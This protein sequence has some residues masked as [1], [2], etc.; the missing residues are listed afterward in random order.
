MSKLFG[1]SARLI[2]QEAVQSVDPAAPPTGF[3]IIYPKT[4]GKWYI[5][6]SDGTI[7]EITNQNTAAIN[8]FNYYNFT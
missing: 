3:S 8:L 7:V 6:N 2:F 1:T 4:D 5:I